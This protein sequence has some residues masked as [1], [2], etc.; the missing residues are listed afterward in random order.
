MRAVKQ[1]SPPALHHAPVTSPVGSSQLLICCLELA[2]GGLASVKPLSDKIQVLSSLSP[3]FSTWTNGLFCLRHGHC[4]WQTR[5]HPRTRVCEY[6][7][8]DSGLGGGGT[9]HADTHQ[10]RHADC[11]RCP[12]RFLQAKHRRCMTRLQLDACCCVPR[13]FLE[14]VTNDVCI[15]AKSILVWLTAMGLQEGYPCNSSQTVLLREKRSGHPQL[16]W[17]YLHRGHILMG[18]QIVLFYQTLIHCLLG[19]W[20]NSLC[21]YRL[22]SGTLRYNSWASRPERDVTGKWQLCEYCQLPGHTYFTQILCV[23]LSLSLS[24]CIWQTSALLHSPFF[25][26]AVIRQHAHFI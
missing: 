19:C 26:C 16:N 10:H 7:L 13:Q 25:N 5:R 3:R 9:C 21:L 1:P 17:P 18:H 24:L 8:S 6:T 4:C 22:L 15:V 23:L 2:S 12:H 11:V 20:S 14:C